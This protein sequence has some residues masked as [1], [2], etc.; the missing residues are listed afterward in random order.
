MREACSL[1]WSV[2][3]LLFRSRVSLEAEILTL[4]HQLNIQR[5]HLPKRLTLS[6]MDRLIFVGLYRLA[7]STLNVLTIVKPE[8][9][10]RLASCRVQVVLALEVTTSFRPTDGSGRNTPADP[11][12]EHCQSAVGSAADPWRVAQA[13]HRDGPDQ[14]RQVYGQAK[15]DGIAAMDLFVVPTISFRLLY[16]LLIMRQTLRLVPRRSR[17]NARGQ[18]DAL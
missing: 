10:V 12:D 18:V 7:P 6:A 9:V 5:R 16:G 14:R 1:V 8:T 15:G 4:R 13:R 17:A 2:L 11:R 3:V